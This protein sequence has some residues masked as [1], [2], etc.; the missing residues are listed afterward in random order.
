MSRWLSGGNDRP[1]LVYQ[2]LIIA[3]A[4]V[5]IGITVMVLMPRTGQ[6]AAQAEA[7][8]LQRTLNELRVVL[9]A[10]S[11]L[12]SGRPELSL[13]ENPLD[14]LEHGLQVVDG[15][16]LPSNQPPGSWCF[17]GAQLSYRLL[18]EQTVAGQRWPAGSLLRWQIT[19]VTEPAG[20]AGRMEL[21]RVEQ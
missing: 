4:A 3:V 14:R 8:G 2:L 15:P 13:L 9:A 5:V 10:K 12:A 18:Y 1:T 11:A 21:L 19:P 17:E 16:C 20:E 6:L 7:A